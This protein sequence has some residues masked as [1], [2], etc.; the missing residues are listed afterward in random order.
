LAEPSDN[1]YLQTH[2][3]QCTFSNQWQL[4][5]SECWLVNV[6][7]TASGNRQLKCRNWGPPWGVG[8]IK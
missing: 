2:S 5:A 8:L 7:Q 6:Q 3:K 1:E 4:T